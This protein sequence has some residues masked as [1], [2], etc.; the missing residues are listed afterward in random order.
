MQR[1]KETF[2][3]LIVEVQ[4]QISERKSDKEAE[5]GEA[6]KQ[7]KIEMFDEKSKQ[8]LLQQIENLSSRKK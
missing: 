5:R 4:Q 7:G 1:D 8:I 6:S 3:P 2:F